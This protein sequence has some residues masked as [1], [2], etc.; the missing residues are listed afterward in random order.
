MFD[1]KHEDGIDLE[2]FVCG[3]AMFT[4]GDADQKLRFLFHIYDLVGEGSISKT[5]LATL[6]R[7]IPT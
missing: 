4:R 2:D 7:H 1:T 5:E 3:L 6:L